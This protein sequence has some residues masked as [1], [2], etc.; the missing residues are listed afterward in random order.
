MSREI[1]KIGGQEITTTSTAPATWREALATFVAS[2]DV[3]ESSRNLY[4]RTLKLF[5][6]WTEQEGKVLATL[7]Q[8]DL[9]AYKDS[10]FARGLSSLSVGSYLT[11]LRKFFEW[12][13]AN[14]IYPNIA[15]GLKT[16]K[17]KQQFVK[18]HLTD[19]KSREL[20][21]HFKEQSLRD[22]AIV[23]L[24]LRCGLRT[25]EIVRANISDITLRGGKRILKVWGKGHDVADDFVVLT[26]KTYLPIK[27]Y[28]ATRPKAKANEPL[29]SS[30][31]HRNTGERLTTRTISGLIKGGL[32]SIGLDS[33][34]YTAH[35]LRHT[36][37]TTIL[38][39]GGTLMD[40]QHVL[41]HTTPTTTQIYLESIKEELRI[42]NA[43]ESL[44]DAI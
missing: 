8:I 17:R 38:K 9:L 26:D 22:Y 25:I 31:S 20:L 15:K 3:K 32:K 23:N 43:P 37:A 12:A 33:R 10:L 41:R 1:V 29:F 7:T 28:L 11:S 16:P 30:D 5:F 13:E 4:A 24:A 36:C 39:H 2:Q 34:E 27:E 42:E 14:K 44:L 6:E 18:Q 21:D 35:S 40:A 19:E